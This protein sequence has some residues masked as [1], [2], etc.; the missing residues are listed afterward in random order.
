MRVQNR[1][2]CREHLPKQIKRKIVITVMLVILLLLATISIIGTNK[3]SKNK[4][5]ML[6]NAN[7]EIIGSE[8]NEPKLAAGMIPVKY[9]RRI[10]ANN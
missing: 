1:C 5:A 9:E 6:E 2:N 7:I 4:I 8:P 10:L 3:Y